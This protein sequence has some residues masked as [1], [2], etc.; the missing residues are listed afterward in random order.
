MSSDLPRV[1]TPSTPAPASPTGAL[2]PGWA[3]GD[4]DSEEEFP[5]TPEDAAELARLEAAEA[6]DRDADE[7]A[8]AA[9]E[10]AAQR[11]KVRTRW[12][13]FL[14]SLEAPVGWFDDVYANPNA[15]M[16]FP[17]GSALRRACEGLRTH[18]TFEGVVLA[19]VILNGVVIGLGKPEAQLD[20]GAD[21]ILPTAV[22]KTF[23][24]VFL[25]VFA[26]EAVIKIIA[27]GFLIGEDH[28]LRS[29]WNI[30]D[31]TVVVAGI[32]DL[33]SSSVGARFSTL[34]LIRTLQPLRSLNK[35]KSGRLVLETL[36]K[37]FPLLVDVVLFM[38]WFVVSMTVLGTVFFGGTMTYR[39][40]YPRFESEAATPADVV[41][42]EGGAGATAEQ[43]ELARKGYFPEACDNLVDAWLSVNETGGARAETAALEAGTTV[44]DDSEV[45]LATKYRK[46]LGV[47]NVTDDAVATNTSTYYDR[48]RVCC[49]SGLAPFD[50]YVKFDRFTQGVFVVLQIM[51]IDGWNEVTW[52]ICDANGWVKPMIYTAVVV[53]IGGFVVIQLFT[54][55]ICATLGDV[56]EEEKEEERE[57]QEAKRRVAAE[58]ATSQTQEE[59]D[60]SIKEI[61]ETYRKSDVSTLFRNIIEHPHF[62]N[63]IM[64]CIAFNSGLMITSHHEPAKW[65]VTFS[66]GA[67]D[68]FT[69]VFIVEFVMKHLGLGVIQYWKSTWNRLDGFIVIS[70]V[71]EWVLVQAASSGGS[72]VNL[73]FLRVFRIFRIIRTFRVLRENKE[74]VKILESAINGIQAMWV[75]LVV[76][77]LLLII[78]A[79]LGVQ[80]FGGQGDL[81]DERLGFKDVGSA[82]LTLFVV[83]TGENTFEVA[84]ATMVATN[85]YAGL[86]MVVWLV[87]ST[88]ILSLILGIL[89][90]AITAEND[91]L[92]AKQ[93]EKK[94]EKLPPPE[95]EE[96]EN[97]REKIARLE[98]EATIREEKAE[99]RRR[100][101]AARSKAD[102]AVVR[103]WLIS[104]GEEKH[105]RETLAIEKSLTPGEKLAAR[106]RLDAFNAASKK[107]AAMTGIG[108]VQKLNAYNL[109]D[110]DFAPGT[111]TADERLAD[112][113][114]QLAE[115][116]A[117]RRKE[118]AAANVVISPEEVTPEIIT[119]DRV[120][121]PKWKR[122]DLEIVYHDEDGLPK[123]EARL[124][125]EEEDFQRAEKLQR[126]NLEVIL[127]VLKIRVANR[128]PGAR[129][130]RSRRRSDSE[131]SDDDGAP[132]PE[133]SRSPTLGDP[134]QPG[135][136]RRGWGGGFGA[137]GLKGGNGRLLA[138]RIVTHPAFEIAILLA[139][140]VSSGL[141][142]AETHTFP[143]KGTTTYAWFEAVDVVFTV[144]FTMEMLAKMYALGLYS[145]SGSYFKSYF[146]ILDVV[147]VVSA[148]FT[149]VFG[150]GGALKSLRLLRAMRPLRSIH[151]L[152]ALRL[153]I[154]AVIA[155]LPAITH[156]CVLGVGL[157]T[158]L[159]IMG[160]ELFQ[161]KMWYCTW[162]PAE[163]AGVAADREQCE[164][165]GGTW[166]NNKFNFDNFGE[167]MISVFII[168]TGDNWQDIMY[169]AMDSVGVGEAPSRDNSG[170][171]AAYFVLVVLIA[172]LFWANLFVSALV[173]NFNRM[174]ASG[175]PTLVSDEQRRW[176]QAMQLATISHLE[177]WRRTPPKN[178]GYARRAIHH[179]CKQPAFDYLVTAVI[180]LNL[181]AMVLYRH[182]APADEK[183]ALLVFDYFFTVFY[184]GEAALL[185]AA[186]GW[187]MY[188]SNFMYKVD[189]FVALAG[190]L[191]MAI[192]V[193]RNSAFGD[194][195]R[196]ARFLR[197]FKLI[198]V[199]RGLRT[200]TQTFVQSLPAVVNISLLSAL[201]VFIYSCLG[202]SLYGDME[203][204]FIHGVALSEY[205]NFRT[206]GS[207]F[208]SLFVTYTGN[209]MSFF[210]EM[211]RDD[212][213]DLE[214]IPATLPNCDR[215][216][217]TVA[218]FFTF[219][220]IAIF[221][222]ANLFVAVILEQFS[223][224]ADKEGVYQG[225]GIV[226][227]VITTV[228][229]RKV[230]KLI[231]SKV[232]RT[233]SKSGAFTY[234]AAHAA[235]A[236]EL[237]TLRLL[238][239]GKGDD[240]GARSGG[241]GT[242]VD[243]AAVSVDEIK[244]AIASASQVA[245][246][247]R[248][249][250]VGPST[251]LDAAA[252]SV[253]ELVRRA[254]TPGARSAAAL[255]PVASTTP[256]S[257]S[258]V[259]PAPARAA[260]DPPAP[261]ELPG[262]SASRFGARAAAAVSAVTAAVSSAA[263]AA[264]YTAR[265]VEDEDEDEDDD[266][267][268]TDRFNVDGARRRV[269]NRS[270]AS[271]PAR[272]TYSAYSGVSSRYGP[273][274]PSQRGDG[275]SDE[276]SDGGA[277]AVSFK[278]TRSEATRAG[279][280]GGY[281]GY[282]G[283]ASRGGGSG[284]NR[285]RRGD[286]D[287]DRGRRRAEY[288]A[289]EEIGDLD[290]DGIL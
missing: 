161:G 237:E 228:Q 24:V 87:I 29:Y 276:D 20:A 26:A 230:A 51:T 95:S 149:L 266:D 44:P 146:N 218:Y 195:F 150:G 231:R 277:T 191:D 79:I 34:R 166:R 272:S 41:L 171:A 158:V 196:I 178:A 282:G 194:M 7:E 111:K 163:H 129:G 240:G 103:R 47:D 94:I 220:V 50:D 108:S 236:S 145:T 162:L 232:I 89:I 134:P 49:D 110:E 208:V 25:M 271:S 125:R 179:Y 187:K 96:V 32:V 54:S 261:L 210:S 2:G 259:A 101:L 279:G 207:A 100:R 151:R 197:L 173:D 189:F 206:F 256:A 269:P 288:V 3:H 65:Y 252:E 212:R 247:N 176:Q 170:W 172:M 82:L 290:I 222:L 160:M 55:V 130:R 14:E 97:P 124:M 57:L 238:G 10:K 39:A 180:F 242:P 192:P 286:G 263:A 140:G 273:G 127:E 116:V 115:R 83:S 52:P 112:M 157:G 114:R 46:S 119:W 184:M 217:T 281:G 241:F 80:L 23:E 105:T 122:D 88:S 289:D 85:S 40:Y 209:W 139:I 215:D 67:E 186:M 121:P 128:A 1:R 35:F 56:E 243:A 136:R 226:D 42:N 69:I 267:D 19:C 71:V 202:V 287:D 30:L 73:S 98:R 155:S 90:D 229:L 58:K 275:D 167:A 164:A 285:G 60:R 137:C 270:G 53:V 257:A 12:A 219:V 203:G 175:G 131:D 8:I 251:P 61:D 244:S 70:S 11:R 76:W 239:S 248:A 193:L 66:S 169:V 205:S 21:P 4:E 265:P 13:A 48:P 188:W 284:P 106:R 216:F 38:L 31:F 45:C 102:V 99:V 68:F 280:Y 77:A 213:C 181:I 84:Y 117:A 152:P 245:S 159:S 135:E 211:F 141:L 144:I 81:D 6:E 156:V 177:R 93:E 9:F 143:A 235:G 165:L 126:A 92:E 204:P 154:N 36:G 278:T 233:R 107:R 133:L 37:S 33:I 253:M 18:P 148:L 132:R 185:I 120:R 182:D 62:D 249:R 199:S 221:L 22:S 74:F 75:F 113:K 27:Q 201:V 200:L 5:A 91:E 174:A 250:G 64:A 198:K 268:S 258:N 16:V 78:F 109:E 43:V 138:L 225:S 59:L 254:S 234:T 153:V 118:V 142:A 246:A 260:A 255:T 28:Y 72:G 227:L 190:F 214:V 17:P 264:T 224:C 262:G 147:V 123:S 223:D 86:Y 183:L 283:A 104:I 63:F 274:V 15:L 168:S